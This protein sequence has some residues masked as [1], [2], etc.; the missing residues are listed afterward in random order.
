MNLGSKGPRTLAVHAES[1]LFTSA[2]SDST[3]GE[4]NLDQR[5][6]KGNPKDSCS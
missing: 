6:L 2:T 4:L 1:M 5:P 3:S